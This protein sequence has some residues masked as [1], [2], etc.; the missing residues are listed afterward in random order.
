MQETTGENASLVRVV[1][2]GEEDP[3]AERKEAGP[4]WEA[5]REKSKGKVGL[6]Q[7]AEGEISKE[8]AGPE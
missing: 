4:K 2:T 7:E 6:E 5:E 3:E 8:E 1:L